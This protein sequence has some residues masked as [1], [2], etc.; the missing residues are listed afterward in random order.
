M[1]IGLV[2]F[3]FLLFSASCS[4]G[5]KGPFFWKVEK[6]GR[7]L[8]VLGTV[9]VGV[10][11]NS[12]QC[13]QTISDALEQSVLVW[14]EANVQ[15]QQHELAKAAV[16]LSVDASGQSFQS[17]SEESQNF[18]KT[19]M[20][21]EAFEEIQ[22]LSY[23]GLV[24]RTRFLC[25]AEHRKFVEEQKA[26]FSK[27][28]VMGQHLDIQIQQLAQTKNLPQ[29]YLDESDYIGSMIRAR[30]EKISKEQV[31]N[32]VKVYDR[33][34]SREELAKTIEGQFNLTLEIIEKYK[35]GEKIDIS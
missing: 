10:S 31:E 20:L 27:K 24:F 15:Q 35:A 23:M 4:P 13:S 11:L 18:F 3:I 7:N 1:R 29:N 22:Q 5:P 21:P 32:I 30:A 34:C 9:H 12:L 33:K 14:T 2:L 16:E 25:E 19:K 17:L 28:V 8:Y 6:D 26:L